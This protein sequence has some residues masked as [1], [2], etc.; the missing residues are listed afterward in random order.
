[1]IAQKQISQNHEDLKEETKKEREELLSAVKEFGAKILQEFVD[2]KHDQRWADEKIECFYTLKN[3]IRNHVKKY[4]EVFA[5]ENTVNELN[6]QYAVLIKG[7]VAIV[8][9]VDGVMFSRKAFIDAHE[10]KLVTKIDG[11]P[12]NKGRLWLKSPSRKE[13]INVAIDPKNNLPADTL[14]LWKGYAVEPKKGDCSLLKKHIRQVV[15]SGSEELYEYVLNWVALVLRDPKKLHTA[16]LI[17]GGSGVGKNTFANVIAD[18]LGPHCFSANGFDQVLGRFNG[19]LKD[20]TC[21]II[22]EASIPDRLLGK[23]KSL[24]TE[25]SLPV[26]QK[27]VDIYSIPNSLHFIILSNEESPIRLERDQRRI[28][29]LKAADT[30]KNNT[31]YFDDLHK[32]IDNGGRSAFL[33][34]VLNRDI[35]TFKPYPLPYSPHEFEQKLLRAHSAELFIYASL[36]NECLGKTKLGCDQILVP[37]DE[38]HNDYVDWCK[39]NNHH[40]VLDSYFAKKIINILNLD[41]C[42]PKSNNP[43]ISS[44]TSEKDRPS[45]WV[46]PSLKHCK[47]A[48]QK[49]FR[50]R[51]NIW[52]Q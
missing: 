20:K 24:V 23:F 9:L 2:S 7:C 40:P 46:V 43:H 47:D 17:T 4:E 41:H 21:V 27:G 32:E 37:K 16:L 29:P 22:N 38:L 42:R 51:D 34:D 1:M 45:C 30:Y 50:G 31:K 15:C 14:N 44:S 52:V 12:T 48:F 18:I 35:S 11:K 6:E 10:N 33:Y 25:L 8:R 3:T 5:E 13:Y 39:P 19:H 28:L 36:C 49:E 26:E